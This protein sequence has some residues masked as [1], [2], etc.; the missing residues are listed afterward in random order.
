MNNHTADTGH[1][2]AIRF[3]SGTVKVGQSR[4]VSHRLAQH[5]AAAAV[6]EVT[7]QCIW[8][9]EPVD[10][11]EERERELLAFC[12]AHWPLVAGGEYFRRAEMAM[13]IKRAD[14][15]GVAT[16]EVR[17]PVVVP[18][19]TAEHSP[20]A[21]SLRTAVQEALQSH[22]YIVPSQG[23]VRVYAPAPT[24][25][26]PRWHNVLAALRTADRWGSANLTGTPEIWAE[27]IA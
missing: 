12:L 3:S 13:I 9:S 21:E 4:D 22:T 2:Y 6:H 15:M 25:D 27:V 19:V 23:A 14:D 16:R 11:L 7:A 26:S 10:R 8:I 5:M 1:L 17:G 24:S 20:R 18:G